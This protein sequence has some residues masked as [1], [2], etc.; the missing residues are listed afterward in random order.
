MH[1]RDYL[2]DLMMEKLYL[3]PQ[4]SL[5]KH[6]YSFIS[7]A[8]EKLGHTHGVFFIAHK[9]VNYLNFEDKQAW[10]GEEIVVDEKHHNDL[11]EILAMEKTLQDELHIVK[12]YLRTALSNSDN[13]ADT[14]YL[15]DQN[16]HKYL[17]CRENESVTEVAKQFLL[18]R[19]NKKHDRSSIIK[20]RILTNILIQNL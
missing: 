6:L 4:K 5:K 16:L 20:E 18:D 15:L 9:G 12:H 2:L 10:E 19:E 7:K 11:N 13:N 17:Y 14:Y 8:A 1:F 3:G